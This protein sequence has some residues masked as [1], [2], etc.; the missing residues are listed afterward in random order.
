MRLF[1]AIFPD[2]ELKSYFRDVKQRL[3]KFKRNFTFVQLD[4]VHL[5][6]KFLGDDVNEE[7]YTYYAERLRQLTEEVAPFEYTLLAPKFGFKGQVVPKVLFSPL[8]QNDT[9]DEIANI[10]TEA[11]RNLGSYNIATTKERKQ[12]IQHITLGRIKSHTSRTFSQTFNQV[13]K[14]IPA[15]DFTPK[16]SSIRIIQSKLTPKGPLYKTMDTIE[17]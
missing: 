4:Q 2:D 16:A 10:A 9:F 8:K 7:V 5:T 17:L 11:T 1:V 3:S 12:L 13:L 15:P 14:T 6:A